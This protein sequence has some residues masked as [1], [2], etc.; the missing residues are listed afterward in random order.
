MLAQVPKAGPEV[1]DGFDLALVS[2]CL[3]V[4]VVLSFL[5]QLGLTRSLLIAG[6]RTVVQLLAIGY[7]L[8]QIFAA[9]HPGFVLALL[10]LMGLLAG[11][12][13]TRQTKHRFRGQMSIATG[14]LLLSAFLMTSYAVFVVVQPQDPFDPSYLIPI[15]GMVF[16]NGLTAISL[17]IDRFVIGLIEQRREIETMLGFGASRSE[18]VRPHVREAVRTGMMPMLNS[19]T[20]VGLVSLPGMMTGQILGGT[21]PEQ[22]VRY[23]I[24]MMFLLAGSTALGAGIAVL[25]LRRRLFDEQDRLR[26]ALFHKSKNNSRS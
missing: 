1:L 14:S 7:V 17:A 10:L 11:H 2:L 25:W 22:A 4:N 24:V 16:G 19:M 6:T 3:L 23:Q 18:A 20:V 13:I 21:P 5:I 8:Q 26:L 15:M 9:S 12:A